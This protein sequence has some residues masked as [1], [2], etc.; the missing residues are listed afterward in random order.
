[1]DMARLKRAAAAVPVPQSQAEAAEA[2]AAIGAA[3]RSLAVIQAA[4]DEQVDALK[5]AAEA[6]GGA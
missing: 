4:L 3:Q 6:E 5:A 2:L 1:M